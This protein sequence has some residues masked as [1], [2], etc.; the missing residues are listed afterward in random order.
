MKGLECLVGGAVV[1]ARTEDGADAVAVKLLAHRGEGVA[2][3]EADVLFVEVFD[4]ASEGRCGGVVDV[5]DSGGV[6]NDPLQWA[7]LRGDG[8]DVVDEVVRVGVVEV[9]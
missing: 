7:S 1:G 3:D 6:E 9:G 2:D 5:A 4:G 8:R